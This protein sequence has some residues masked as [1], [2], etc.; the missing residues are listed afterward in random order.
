MICNPDRDE[1]EFAVKQIIKNRGKNM[2]GDMKP[3]PRKLPKLNVNAEK[4]KDMIDWKRS[5]EPILA[6]NFSK[7]EI[8]TFLVTPLEVP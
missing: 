5:K 7:E 8:K 6:C 3:W 4:L 2:L 1:R